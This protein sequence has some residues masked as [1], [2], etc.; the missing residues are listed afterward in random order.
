MSYSISGIK[1]GTVTPT[2]FPRVLNP[3]SYDAQLMYVKYR[4]KNA[5][6]KKVLP[7]FC[8][9]LLDEYEAAGSVLIR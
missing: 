8:L 5:P 6:R 9:F 7:L 1:N 3:A 2:S 4:S